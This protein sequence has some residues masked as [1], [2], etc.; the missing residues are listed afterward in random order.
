M[1]TEES[2]PTLAPPVVGDGASGGT[3]R[4]GLRHRDGVFEVRL[5]RTLIGR[6]ESCDIVL[7]DPLVSRRHAALLLTDAG[8]EVEDLGS[9]NGLF[10]NGER[11]GGRT[12]LA[13]GDRLVI[14]RQQ[15]TVEKW[16][17][18]SAQD[19]SGTG[20]QR[21]LSASNELDRF[22]AALGGD[23]T[24]KGDTFDL[25]GGVADKALALGRGAEAERI[26]GG[27]LETLRNAE[28][29]EQ[30]L[31]PAQAARAVD[32][33]VRLAEVS[34]KGSW[35]DYAVELFTIRSEPLPAATVD[36]LYRVLRSCSR[37]DVPLLRR[38]VRTLRAE[39][40]RLGPADRFVVQRI[41]GLVALATLR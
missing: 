28:R 18:A 31:S 19:C 22:A 24:T 14:G 23:A 26:L 7:D 16:T 2:R 17:A 25:L 5:P 30:P 8:L 6:A 12:R 9:V 1:P 34:G 21:T 4:F 38:Y 39:F 11:G 29:R 40:E 36:R 32:Y 27:F 3:A 20:E 10:V 33:A 37:I 35:I 13:L 15:L 41:E